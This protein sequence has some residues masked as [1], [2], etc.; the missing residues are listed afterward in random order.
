M[1]S[2]TP[3]KIIPSNVANNTPDKLKRISMAIARDAWNSYIY[4]D[5]ERAK[6]LAPQALAQP[7]L[8]DGFKAPM[9]FIMD[10]PSRDEK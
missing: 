7:H 1:S 8:P 4:D 2:N 10:T 6:K 5:L 3:G 9:Q